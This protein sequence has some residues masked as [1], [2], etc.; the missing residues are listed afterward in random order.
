VPVA[1]QQFPHR[2]A[3]IGLGQFGIRLSF[4]Y[5]KKRIATFRVWQSPVAYLVHANARFGGERAQ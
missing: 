1:P 2:R 3:A 5:C 4:A